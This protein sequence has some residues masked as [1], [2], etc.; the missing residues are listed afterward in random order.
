MSPFTKVYNN[1]LAQQAQSKQKRQIRTGLAAGANPG[2][3][4]RAVQGQGQRPNFAVNSAG[5]SMV[6]NALRSH[7]IGQQN[8][9]Q[10]N[11]NMAIPSNPAQFSGRGGSQGVFGSANVMFRG[12]TGA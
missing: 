1:Q 12:L 6:T 9:G 2:T 8:S 3:S 10:P 11:P 4:K 5:G 7:S